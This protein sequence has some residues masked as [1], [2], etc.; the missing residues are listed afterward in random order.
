MNKLFI[1]ALILLA[2]VNISACSRHQNPLLAHDA[3]ISATVLVNTS[4]L[5]TQKHSLKVPDGA[6]V[7]GQCMDKQLKP[8]VCKPFLKTM[9]A[10]LQALPGY[11]GITMADLTDQN[12]WRWLRGPYKKACFESI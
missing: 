5:A 7:F 8:Q 11:K 9:L 3:K 4:K 1:S 10:T 12:A 2:M 6:A